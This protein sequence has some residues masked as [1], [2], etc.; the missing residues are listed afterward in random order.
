MDL[1]LFIYPVRSI[2]TGAK[3][4][5]AGQEARPVFAGGNSPLPLP[6]HESVT[7]MPAICFGKPMC[8][9]GAINQSRQGQRHTQP[10]RCLEQC[11][12]AGDPLW[13]QYKRSGTPPFDG[14]LLRRY[15]HALHYHC[16]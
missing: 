1:K 9:S 7:L 13:R 12:V 5:Q 2:P 16:T 3:Q 14:R 10:R 6:I 8:L 15:G 4:I 11:D